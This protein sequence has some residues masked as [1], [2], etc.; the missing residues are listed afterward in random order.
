MSSGAVHCILLS[1][2][3]DTAFLLI[4]HFELLV[5]FR[6]LQ[7]HFSHENCCFSV[8]RIPASKHMNESERYHAKW[9]KPV[10]KGKVLN[11]S[12]YIG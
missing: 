5:Y 2:C 7:I 3:L 11:A 4:N 12:A 1:L 6:I 9:N 8:T 10:T